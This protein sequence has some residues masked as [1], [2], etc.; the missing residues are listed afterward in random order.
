MKISIGM[1][2]VK[3]GME[4]IIMKI[5]T[6]STGYVEVDFN[7][8]L[9][10]EMSFNLKDENGECLKNNKPLTTIK[11]STMQK[12]I[13]YANSATAK[14]TSDEWESYRR[15]IKINVKSNN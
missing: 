13:D 1:K 6:K 5:I 14:M 15:N 3:S 7:G 9:K 12:E 2:V 11:K 8:K 4:G 10:K